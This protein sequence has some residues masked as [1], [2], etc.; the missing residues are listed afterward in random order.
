MPNIPLRRRA[1]SAQIE[2]RCR[3]ELTRILAV[4]D[5]AAMTG[6]LARLSQGFAGDALS[7]IQSR[8]KAY[9]MAGIQ[10][11][12]FRESVHLEAGRVSGTDRV[13]ALVRYRD[14]TSFM[15]SG[16][17]PTSANDPVQL[18]V[19]LETAGPFWRVATLAEE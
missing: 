17:S 13:W 6:N 1:G 3:S 11:S 18:R 15:A 16:V 9:Q 12:P 10:V 8:F 2:E 19:I 4:V 7:E 5:E 14:R